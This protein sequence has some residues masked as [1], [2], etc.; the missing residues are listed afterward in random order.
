M[1]VSKGGSRY[2]SFT[3]DRP[4]KNHWAY[5]FAY[6]RGRST[7]VQVFGSTTAGSQWSRNSVFNQNTIVEGRSD[8][9]IRDRVQFSYTREFSF[10]KRKGTSTLVSLYYEGRSGLP[11]SYVY[12]ND[13]NGDSISQNDLVAVPTGPSDPRFNFSAMSAADQASYFQFI[14][15]TGLSHYAG[16]YA[17]RNAFTQP[18]VNR[19]DLHVSQNV[20]I[21]RAVKLELFADFTNFGSFL[22]RSLF[23]WQQR[24]TL[25]DSDTWWRRQIGNATY[26]AAGKIQ[27]T[28]SPSSYQYDN[29]QSR[30][31]LQVGARL[32]F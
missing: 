10:I 26:D 3:L 17:P 11:F 9:E 1:N 19:L 27:P 12:A 22:T 31:R 21:F 2:I 4:L 6:T 15:E 16:G 5:N 24:T 13:L 7:D 32:K 20:P 14:Q 30:W 18:W 29:T 23:N 25:V 8:F 28:Y